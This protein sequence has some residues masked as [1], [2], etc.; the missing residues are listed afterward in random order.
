MALEL[1]IISF[2]PILSSS[3]WFQE[4]EATLKYLLF[5]AL[6]SRLILI[7]IIDLHIYTL[8]L[9]GLLI[10]LGAAP[11]HFWFP[12]V[13]KSSSWLN[14]L[15]LITWQ[16]IA[17]LILIISSFRNTHPQIISLIGILNALLGGLSGLN[18]T[19]LRALLAYSS[20]GHIGWIITVSLMSPFTS[21][22]YLTFYIFISIPI[23]WASFLSNIQSIKF[24]N[25]PRPYIFYLTVLPCI[26]S[27]RGLPPFIGFFPKLL[28]LSS[29]SSILLPLL[30]IFG[31]LINLSY[32]LNFFFALFI[33]SSSLKYPLKTIPTSYTLSLFIWIA[34]TPI[35]AIF[36]LLFRL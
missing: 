15:I 33:S 23:I 24:S 12:S 21:I 7:R 11:F 35:P 32:Y 36:L 28:A 34:C 3:N 6:G 16:K 1:N 27:L 20:I 17:P 9:F 4:T 13:I 10:K 25:K 19:H 30:L 22:L 31:S 26:L 18:Q 14:A 5:Q 8:A 29:F 2:V